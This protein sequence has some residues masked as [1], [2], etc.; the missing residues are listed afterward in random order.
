MV[1]YYNFNVFNNSAATDILKFKAD[2]TNP[3]LPINEKPNEYDISIIRF[4]VP[5]YY[6]PIFDFIDNYYYMSIEYNSTYVTLPIVYIQHNQD[7]TSRN[8]YEIQA[9]IQMINETVSQLFIQLSNIVQLPTSEVP[10]FAYNE[11][12]KLISLFANSYYINNPTPQT[13]PINIHCDRHVWSILQG[14]PS[15]YDG[16]QQAATRYKL[17]VMDLKNNF[18]TTTN[19]YKMTQQGS[20][21]ENICSFNGIVFTTNLCIRNEFSG[22]KKVIT[23]T[24]PESYN[25]G[26]PI[27]QDYIPADISVDTFHNNVVYNAIT[28]YRQSEIIGESMIYNMEIIPYY[29]T[30]DGILHEIILG[31]GQSGNIK[32]MFTK[33]NKNKYA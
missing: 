30:K 29:Q 22:M 24:N 12:T 28:P 1:I 32:M 13:L 2:I 33:K 25:I 11:E 20:T 17:W 14:F 26:L 6:T 16:S 9:L 27:L 3:I 18:N 8:V 19:L 31:S 10:Y 21:F 23:G 15:Y 5:N 4:S 7:I